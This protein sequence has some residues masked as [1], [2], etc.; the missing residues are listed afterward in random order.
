MT[1]CHHAKPLKKK[2]KTQQTR[3][4]V[5]KGTITRKSAVIPL[6]LTLLPDGHNHE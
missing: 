6:T 3:A 2:K 5:Q 4:H 1:R